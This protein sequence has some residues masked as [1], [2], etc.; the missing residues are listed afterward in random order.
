MK[1]TAGFVDGLIGASLEFTNNAYSVMTFAGIDSIKGGGL[2]P[3]TIETTG[4]I[5]G[6]C[7]VDA[8]LAG[9]S[10]PLQY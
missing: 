4:G 1:L 3:A 7:V 8:N 2:T 6:V 5:P 9:A 10:L